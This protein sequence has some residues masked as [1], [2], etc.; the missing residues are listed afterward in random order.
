MSQPEPHPFVRIDRCVS[1]AFALLLAC[2]GG[3]GRDPGNTAPP[4]TTLPPSTGSDSGDA[5][6]STTGGASDPDTTSGSTPTSTTG[7]VD[8]DTGPASTGPDI[9]TGDGGGVP[10]CPE[11]GAPLDC[12]PG[13]GSGRND[14]CVDDP[15]CF[16]DLVQSS[17]TGVIADH[18]EWFD[19]STGQ[20]FVLEVELYMNTVVEYVGQSECS[21]RDPNAGDE[22][23]VKHDNAFAENFDILTAEGVARWGDGI[24]TSKC[25]PAWF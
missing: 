11:P 20:P 24:Y 14:T 13:P 17:V 21:I 5:G 8:P 1:F 12:S 2:S 15:S 6:T 19:Q 25:I 22:I 3:E 7:A 9:T 23:V 16:L 10:A 18:P 4:V